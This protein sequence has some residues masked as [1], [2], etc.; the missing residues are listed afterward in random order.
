M[1]AIVVGGVFALVKFQVF[2]TFEPHL[3][4]THE[5]SHRF[6]S[7]SYVHIDVTATLHNSS[8]VKVEVE[9]AYFSLQ[10]IAPLLDEQID[11]L[12]TQVIVDEEF[13]HFQWPRLYKVPWEWLA[14]DLIVEPGESHQETCEFIVE[15]GI[16]SVGVYTYFYNPDFRE[17]AN[18]AEGWGT[19][20]V[21]DIVN[22]DYDAG[23][24]S[25][26]DV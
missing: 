15:I 4:V 17:G 19:Y 5:V 13:T 16:A 12:Y 6:V 10:Q 14:G 23:L 3:T 25:E 9:D 2:R 24:S 1:V 26:V 18:V 20:T 11:D 7:P 22:E 8:R 21:Y